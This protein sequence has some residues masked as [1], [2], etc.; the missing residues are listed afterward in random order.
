MTFKIGQ[1]QNHKKYKMSGWKRVVRAPTNQLEN[2]WLKNKLIEHWEKSGLSRTKWLES[3]GLLA[4][5]A[6]VSY[7]LSGKRGTSFWVAVR[8]ATACGIN[9]AELQFEVSKKRSTPQSPEKGE[10]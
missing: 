9:L 5:Q 8:I 6:N 4:K 10:K 1:K 2:I 7:L 3:L